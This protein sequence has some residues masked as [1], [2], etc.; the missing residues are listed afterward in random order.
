MLAALFAGAIGIGSLASSSAAAI[1]TAEQASDQ[2]LLNQ[3]VQAALTQENDP[4]MLTLFGNALKN[5]GY[6]SYADAI[7]ARAARLS[8]VEQ[9]NATTEQ[10]LAVINQVLRSSSSS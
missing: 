10:Q 5:A 2:A 8:Q 1:P 7:M 3:A 6:A 9:S 4:G